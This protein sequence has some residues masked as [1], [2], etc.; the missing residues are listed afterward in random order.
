[1]RRRGVIA[2]EELRADQNGHQALLDARIETAALAAPGVEGQRALQILT[3]DRS[4]EC[5]FGDARKDPARAGK[6]FGRAVRVAHEDALAAGGLADALR[7][8]RP[9]DLDILDARPGR[10]AVHV[11]G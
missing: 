2:V 9:L 8:Q 3:R 7:N 1:P 6:L 11:V 4:P 10:V 5:L